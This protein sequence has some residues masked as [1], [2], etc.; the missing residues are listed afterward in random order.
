MKNKV[1]V[2]KIGGGIISDDAALDAFLEK[3]AQLSGAKVLIH[4]GGK[5]AT[6]LSKKLGVEVKMIEGRR[7]T[8]K[9]ALEVTAMVYAGL[10]NT[11]ICAKLVANGC[12]ALGLSGADANVIASTKRPANP[13][14]FGFVGDVKRVNGAAL[15]GFI[16]QG[17]TPVLCSI[18]HDQNGQ[19]LNTNADTIASEVAIAMSEHFDVE[20]IYCFEKNGVL[21]DINDEESVIPEINIDTYAQLCQEGIVNEGMI[22]KLDNCFNA[23]KRGVTEVVIGNA[24]APFATKGTYTVLR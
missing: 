20:L 23:L 4:G 19:L 1:K 3:F 5:L 12:S 10:I 18:T 6:E 17:H 14:D 22:P 11:S 15:A 16:T 9:E 2:I 7:V 24:N 8:T 21:R 13:I